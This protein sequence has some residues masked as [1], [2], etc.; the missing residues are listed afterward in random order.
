MLNSLQ[1]SDG[2]HQL[3]NAHKY[4]EAEEAIHRLLDEYDHDH[5]LFVNL[6][7]CQLA[8][9]KLE[10]ALHNYMHLYQHPEDS[11]EVSTIEAA[12]VLD[13]SRTALQVCYSGQTRL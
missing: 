5:R 1:T 9:E 2:I 4:K 12:L 8:Q 10:E 6:A 13:K 3:M 7:R 11:D